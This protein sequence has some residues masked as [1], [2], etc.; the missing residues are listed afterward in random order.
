MTDNNTNS[1]SPAQ[2]LAARFDAAHA[3]TG[4]ASYAN[5]ARFARLFDRWHDRPA[6]GLEEAINIGTN[7]DNFCDLF[8]FVLEPYLHG[9][10]QLSGL[11]VPP[12]PD[13]DASLNAAREAEETPHD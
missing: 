3:V 10:S 12:A 11:A 7:Y 4:S 5:L 1:L 9:S 6:G 2:Q 8:L 13:E